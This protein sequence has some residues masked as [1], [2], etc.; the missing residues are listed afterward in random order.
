MESV[1]EFE[2][3]SRGLLGPNALY[4]QSVK[5]V[6]RR[7]RGRKTTNPNTRWKLNGWA[8]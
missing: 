6:P 2:E 3:P 1:G 7:H 5:F 8:D 4:D